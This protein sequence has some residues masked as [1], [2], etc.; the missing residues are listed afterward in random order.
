MTHLFQDLRYAM[1]QLRNAPGFSL[2]AILTLAL[3]IGANTAIASAAYAVLLRSLPFA[4]ADRLVLIKE[5][6]PQAGI[7]AAG[8]RDVVDWRAQSKSFQ[9]LAAYSDVHQNYAQVAIGGSVYPLKSAMISAQLFPTLGIRP[10]LGSEFLAAADTDSG[11]HVAMISHRLWQSRFGGDAGVIGSSIEINGQHFTLIGVMPDGKQYPFATDLWLPLGQMD[12]DERNSRQYHATDVIGRLRNGVTLD[13]ARVELNGIADRLAQSYP[14]TNRSVGVRIT[15]LR[16]ALV[17]QL[18]PTLLALFAAVALVLFIAC[19]NIA[20]LLLVRASSRQREMAVRTALGA[21]RARLLRQFLAESLVLSTAGAT[22][23]VLLAYASMPLLNYGLSQIA[24]RQFALGQQIELS[25][26]VLSFTAAL[27]LLTGIVFSCFP[28]LHFLPDLNDRLRDG[29]RTVVGGRSRIRNV[30]AAGEL[31]LAVVVLFSAALLLRSFQKLLAVDPG[32]R[33]DHLL[34]LKIDLPANIYSKPEQVE[35]F[36]MRLQ[37]RAEHIPGVTSAAVTNV[38]PLTPSRSMT[39]F[40]V[41]GAP[42]PGAG[43]FPVT[44]IRFVSPSYFRTLGIGLREGRMLEQRDVDDQTGTFLVNEAFA[45]RYLGGRDAV[46]RRLMMDVLTA[47]P[48]AVPII[49]VVADAKDL[50]VDAGTE[51]VIYAAGYSNGQILLVRTALD[52]ESVAS[53]IREAVSSM[54]RSLGVSEVKTMD[55][56]LSDS[57]A[58]PRLSSLLLGFFALLSV[59]L[60]SLGVYGVLAFA[61]RQRVREIGIRMALGAQRAQGLRLFLKEGALLVGAGAAVGI[62]VALVVG[63]LLSAILF[64]VTSADPL[65]ATVAFAVLALVGLGAACVPALRAS[66]TDPIEVLRAE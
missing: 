14:A 59:G 64:D 66:K 13:Q 50:G 30:L 44:Q 17:G 20:N 10:Q 39:R 47:H 55:G 11:M 45:R 42:P 53:S 46:G 35:R 37:E 48:S 19:G 27:A 1:R 28:A 6:H 36:S 57:L 16:N 29:Q 25:L 21:T 18:R 3:G 38:L 31:A 26:P 8:F 12:P 58:R 2:I 49:G 22:A 61:A 9:S 63:R 7:V 51:P 24:D 15:P 65:S 43:N 54:D 40:A 62:V 33:T 60:A 52:P 41:Q 5:T 4:D 32:F 23:G 34:A 56:V